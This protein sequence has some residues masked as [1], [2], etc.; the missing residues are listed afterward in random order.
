MKTIKNEVINE[1]IV[2]KSRFITIITP[3]YDIN[4][5]NKKIDIIKKNYKDATHYCYGFIINGLEKIYD[6]GEPSG[7]AGKPILNV[8]KKNDLTNVLCVVVRY[9][10]GIKLGAGGLIRAYSS[11]VSEALNKSEFGQL[12]IG[13]K[14]TIEFDYS[15]IKQIDYILKS[16]DVDKSF[17][18]KIIYSFN[19]TKEDYETIKDSLL[20]IPLRI[21]TQEAFIVKK[22]T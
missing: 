7:T 2:N 18:E 14:I 9:F 4:E 6:D 20:K 21:D 19:V 15:Y 12:V 13:Y 10:G 3:I 17:D 1:I 5:V 11:S 22:I 8:L 16:F